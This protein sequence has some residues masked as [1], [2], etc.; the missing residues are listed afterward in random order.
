[1]RDRRALAVNMKKARDAEG[2]RAFPVKLIDYLA[3]LRRDTAKPASA[4][5]SSARDAGSGTMLDVTLKAWIA[6]GRG[7]HLHQHGVVDCK[8]ERLEDRFEPIQFRSAR[9]VV[10]GG[11]PMV[12]AGDMPPPDVIALSN[13]PV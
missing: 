4:S 8:I 6:D 11:R 9:G 1:M 13:K 3:D 5:P 2:P 10:L 7:H 12:G